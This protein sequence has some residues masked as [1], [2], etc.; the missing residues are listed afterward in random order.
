MKLSLATALT[1]SAI[2]LTLSLLLPLY[3]GQA[4]ISIP[5]FPSGFPSI[6]A[7]GLIGG[8]IEK[9][10][11]CDILCTESFQGR[12][13]RVSDPSGGTFVTDFSSKVYRE[14]DFSKGNCVVGLATNQDK[15]CSGV[16]KTKAAA[17]IVRCFFGD[18]DP[19]NA[20][21]DHGSGKIIKIIG[22]SKEA[23]TLK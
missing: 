1:V 12:L 22:T 13:I 17:A 5:G 21:Q 20:C 23:C 19:K 10:E 6:G 7:S 8:K 3:D 15:E 9:S 4:G 16:T 2:L 11:R 14:N 18:C